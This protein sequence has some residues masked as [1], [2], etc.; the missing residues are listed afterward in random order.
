MATAQS[1]SKKLKLKKSLDSE[2]AQHSDEDEQVGQEEE[3]ISIYEQNDKAKSRKK[4]RASTAK[5]S[6]KVICLL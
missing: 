3:D 1:S 5:K 4:Q 2:L 6:K